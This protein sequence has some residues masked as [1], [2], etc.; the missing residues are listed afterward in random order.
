MVMGTRGRDITQSVQAAIKPQNNTP[1]TFYV[2]SSY[3]FANKTGNY[4]EN[5]PTASKEKPQQPTLQK[6]SSK[7]ASIYIG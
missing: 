7:K 2:L 4:K 1:F 6:D 3:S 5:K